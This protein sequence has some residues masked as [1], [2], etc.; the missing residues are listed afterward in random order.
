VSRG[1]ARWGAGRPSTKAIGERLHRVDV[2]EWSRRGDLSRHGHFAWSWRR[3]G[4]PSGS[5]SVW[6]SPG[7]AVTLDFTLTIS[8]ERQ[9][10]SQRVRLDRTPCQFGGLRSWFACPCC[11][12]RVAVLYLRFG[13]FAC[14]TCQQVAYASQSEDLIGRMWRRQARLEA[15]LGGSWQRPRGMHRRT[16]ARLLRAVVECEERKDAAIEQF[17]AQLFASVM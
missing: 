1:G 2:R 6:V 7:E 11:G 14:R 4:E 15:R 3:G 9:K 12:R 8:G 13:R 16:Y 5:V 10:V 17:A